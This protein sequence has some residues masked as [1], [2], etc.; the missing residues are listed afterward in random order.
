MFGTVL[1]ILTGLLTAYQS[2]FTGVFS[3][4]LPLIGACVLIIAGI[5]SW[6]RPQPAGRLALIGSIALWTHYGPLLVSL[7]Q[8]V[9]NTPGVSIDWMAQLPTL[10]LVLTTFVSLFYTVA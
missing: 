2:G 8:L 10:L 3:V 1:Y 7:L 5:V 4:S 6:A 9:T